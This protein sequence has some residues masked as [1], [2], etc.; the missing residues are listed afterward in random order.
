MLS[1]ENYTAEHTVKKQESQET[2][3]KWSWQ[4]EYLKWLC[5]YANTD[6]GT[7]II[8]VNDDGYVVGLEDSKAL[9][10]GLPNKITDKLG[11][12]AN[13]NILTAM[14][15]TNLRYGADVP[16]KVASRLVNQYACGLISSNSD[17]ETDPKHK[18]LVKLEEETPIWPATD[19]T[20]EYI[21]IYVQRYP[22]AISC[23]GKYY[24][25]SGSTLHELNGFELQNFLL[26]RASLTWDAVPVPGVEISDLSKEALDLFR[27]KAIR[28][29]RMK[30]S[31]A[32]ISDETLL[33]NLK[34]IEKNQLLRAAVMMFHPDP[35]QFVTGACIKIAFFAPAGA[36]GQNKTDDIIYDDTVHGP[37]ISQ[38]DETID[39]I[40][41]KYLKALISY[42]GLQ[43][44]ETFMWPREA[45]REVLLNA[46]N[47]KR[48]ERGIPIQIK[49]YEDKISIW[50][51]GLWP[52]EL[53]VAKVYERHP[54]L[55]YN[56]KLAN[57]SY[58]SGDI[59]AWGSGF[60]KI[61]LECD[62]LNAPYP[63]INANPKG[64]VEIVCEACDL[65]MK[66]LKHGRYYETYPQGEKEQ[67]EHIIADTDDVKHGSA[68]SPEER[69]SIDRMMDILSRK[70]S[71][72]QKTRLLPVVEHLQ[73]HDTITKQI[74]MELTGKGDSTAKNYINLLLKL[75]VLNREGES[76]STV[77]RR[78]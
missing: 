36:Y 44:I 19:G 64:G 28:N 71:E 2:E 47:H 39:L 69:K 8:G 27:R 42:D 54:S 30:D 75:D 9:L 70:L 60:D 6:G 68:F 7:L 73:I 50:N 17:P 35:E 23:D 14:Q 46:T 63:I 20:M 58:R 33:R 53:D 72:K 32:S 55:P 22:F 26:E 66:L 74:V 67:E 52:D 37:L 76:V 34:L 49:V 12:I 77:Y 3:W 10:E 43:R 16:K 25:R 5:G 51:D 31:D 56:P 59:E 57:V 1:R 41:T 40:Y 29:G 15:G 4:D 65:Y 61:K 18:A 11:I 21:E 78:K 13:V 38:I 48:Y 62:R 45:F 24:K